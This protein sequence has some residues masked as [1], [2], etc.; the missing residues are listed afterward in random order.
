[1]I[2]DETDKITNNYRPVIGKTYIVIL[3]YKEIFTKRR[4]K[5]KLKANF[6]LFIAIKT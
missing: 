1:M 6:E 2:I 4:T 5:L 3:N